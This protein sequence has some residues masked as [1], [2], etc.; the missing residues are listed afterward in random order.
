M[1]NLIS[2]QEALTVAANRPPRRVVRHL[3]SGDRV[4]IPTIE[5]GWY[6]GQLYHGGPETLWANAEV[7]RPSTGQTF[8][9]PIFISYFI[10][11]IK[12][13]DGNMH[14]CTVDGLL[15]LNEA[16]NLAEQARMLAGCIFEVHVDTFQTWE[17]TRDGIKRQRERSTYDW[18]RCA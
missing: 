11:E 13:I 3:E 4:H 5:E 18:I 14:V 2:G 10:N 7:F 8:V 1:T 9:L 16:K 6:Y 15:D 17:T 12:D